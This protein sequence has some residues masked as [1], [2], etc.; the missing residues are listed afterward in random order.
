LRIDRYYFFYCV[1]GTWFTIIAD[2]IL[3][4]WAST[5]LTSSIHYKEW[6]W[7]WCQMDTNLDILHVLLVPF[8]SAAHACCL[9]VTNNL[10]QEQM[11]YILWSIEFL[12]TNTP[13]V[14]LTKVQDIE[15]FHCTWMVEPLVQI[16]MFLLLVIGF[17]VHKLL[18]SFDM[19]LFTKPP[20]LGKVNQQLKLLH[21]FLLAVGHEWISVGFTIKRKLN[22]EPSR[23]L[24]W[25]TWLC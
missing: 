4:C 13:L 17:S 19:L 8:P 5:F 14:A 7:C 12:M 11:R 20:L 25:Y 10:Q 16:Y 18:L 3:Q 15:G 23:W 22:L 24:Q 2:I 21:N 6:Q 1:Q 9:E